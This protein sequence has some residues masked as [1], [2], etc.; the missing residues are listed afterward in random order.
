MGYRE[1]KGNGLRQYCRS[2]INEQNQVNLER[3][4]CFY[5]PY[6]QECTCCGK[7]KN[8]VVDVRVLSRWKL[9]KHPHTAE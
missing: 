6:P 7:V 3:E 2:C 4:D 9:W 5:M 8:I 1:L